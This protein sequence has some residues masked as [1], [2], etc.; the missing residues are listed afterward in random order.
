[1]RRTV[2]LL[3]LALA[4]AAAGPVPVEA[5][6]TLAIRRFEATI[7]VNRD[8]S[9]DVTET[10]TAQFTGSWNGIYRTIPVEYRTPQGF[11]W[12]LRLDFLG[13]TG[14]PEGA[15]LKVERARERHY[16]KYK[17]WVPGAENATRTV[18]L[19]Y[20]AK[21]GLRFFEDHDELYW[22]ITGDEWDVPIDSAWAEIHLPEQAAGVRAIAFNGVYGSTAQEAKVE[23]RGNVI[24]VTMPHPLAFHEGLTAVVGWNKGVVAEPT[25]AERTLGFLGTNWPLGLP[26]V[27]FLAMF[28]IW[29]RRGKDPEELPVTV[30]YEPP[31]GLTPAE[32]GALIDETVDMRDITA[33]MID[34]GVKGHLSIEERETKILFL[35]KNKEYVFHRLDPKPGAPALERH[36]QLVL[37]GIFEGGKR[38]V[39]LSELD[40]EFY[41]HIEGIRSAVYGRLIERKLYR[42]RPDHVKVRW[43]VGGVALGFLFFL[44]GVI[45]GPRFGLTP[46]P[47]VLGGIASGLIMVLFARVMPARTV[48]GARA[49]EKV[50]GF[51]E[52]MSRV[53]GERLERIK[54]APEL[55]ERYLPY[56]MALKVEKKWARAFEGIYREPPSWY[57]GSDPL[58]FSATNFTGRLSELSTSAA[59]TMSSSPRSSGGSGFSGGGSSGGGGGGGGGGGF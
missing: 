49:L 31:K 20:R 4:A 33:T 29:R 53:E 47:F 40:E 46:L 37:D 26:F 51:E 59:S 41:T 18:Q 58:G 17:I 24:R 52:F 16:M 25:K 36:E 12:S 11:N 44:L 50:R 28:N 32:A 1:M 57:V 42:S 39:K 27:V 56:A 45:A 3:L 38:E 35:F 19:H 7:V 55:F 5:Q 2:P 43:M 22:N 21:N 13:A 48:P 15:P 14:G 6:R 30:Q 10:I 34:L 54:Q 23:A 8:G 9:L